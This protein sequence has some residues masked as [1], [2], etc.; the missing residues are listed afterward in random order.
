MR[1]AGCNLLGGPGCA[2]DIL[3]GPSTED[4]ALSMIGDI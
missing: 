3:G 1:P 2:V 4:V